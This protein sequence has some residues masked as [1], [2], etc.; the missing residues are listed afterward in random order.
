M[1]KIHEIFS[2]I[3][4]HDQAINESSIDLWSRK[5]HPTTT[6]NLF[7]GSLESEEKHECD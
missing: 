4:V 1:N 2:A 7:N 5:S 6:H 3:Y